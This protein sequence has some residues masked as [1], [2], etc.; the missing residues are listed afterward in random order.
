[1]FKLYDYQ[2][3]IVDETR[4]KLRQENKGVLIVSPPGSGKSVIIGEIARLATL[5]GSRVLFTVH[6]QELVD[7]ITDTFNKMNVNPNLRTIMT[8]GKVKHR[9]SELPKPNLI[10]V[11]ESQHTR[12]KTY[13]DILDYYD[14]V[15]RLGFSGSPWRM[16]G[17]GFDDIYPAMVEGPSVKWL[18]DNYHLAPFT[19]YAPQTLEGFKKHNGE[20]D[21][22]S[23]DEVL[24]SKIFGDAVSSYLSNANGKQ[25]ILY[26]H[27]VEYSKQYAMAFKEAGVNAASVDGKTPKAERNQIINDFRCGK[28][29]VLCNNDLISEGFDVPNCEVVIMC[30]P[31]ASLVLYL[32][33]SMRCMRYV[34]GKQAMIIDHVG[35]YVRFGLPDDDREWSLTGRNSKGK[36]DAPDIHTCQCCYQVFYD[37][38]ADNRCPYCGEL[39]PEADPRTAEGK[40]EIEK[41]KM[42]EI[43]NRKVKKDDSLISIY[44]HFKARK[45]MNIGSVHRPINAAIRQKGACS[46]DELNGFA[47]YL[48]VKK[49]YIFRLYNHKY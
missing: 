41:A 35:N 14:N 6:R 12:A 28:L 38:T 13:T 16:N 27:S 48:G 42:I 10:I 26:A 46:S 7:Q 29:K 47:E 40:K 5:K 1:M 11:D 21:K 20:Y 9:L 34:D 4:S 25:A 17:Q 31:T 24:G 8:V 43:A 19:Y 44:E 3:R 45:V 30:R 49:N 39:K 22:K 2:Q 37:W 32:Q 33:Q 18:I 23:V 15:P 36:I